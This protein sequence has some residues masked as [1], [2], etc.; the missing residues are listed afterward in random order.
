MTDKN[1]SAMDLHSETVEGLKQELAALRIE[2]NK[3]AREL[4][5]SNNNN[6]VLKLNMSSQADIFKTLEN[7]KSKQDVYVSLLLQSCPDSILV[8][9]EKLRILLCTNSIVNIID[10]PDP[11]L[12]QG[13]DLSDMVGRY[14]PPVFTPE[15][16]SSIENMAASGE[17]KARKQVEVVIAEGCY[18]VTILSFDKGAGIFAGVLVV[19]HNITELA[20]ARVSAENAN[21]AKSDFLA[22]MSHEIRTPMNAILGLL[23]SVGHDPLT[24]RQKSYIAH[25]K[26]SGNSLLN[27]INDILDFSKIEAGKFT[28]SPCNFDLHALLNNIGSLSQVTAREKKLKFTVTLSDDVPKTIFADDNRLRQVLNNIISNAIKYTQEGSVALDVF[29][30]GEMLNFQVTDTGIGIRKEDIA[31]LFSPFEQLDLRKN[32]NVIGTGLGLAITR[33]ICDSVGGSISVSSE[34]GR[35]S[36]FSIKIPLIVGVM[37]EA[38]SDDGAA[39]VVSFPDSRV[40]VVDDLDIN[41][42]VAEA[43]LG[44]FEIKPDL[45]LSGGLALDMIAQNRYDIIFMDQMMPEMDGIETTGNIRR[46]DDYYAAVPIVALTANAL[47]GVKD[48]LL[49]AGFSDYLS[50]PIDVTLLHKCLAKWLD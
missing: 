30:G 9:D 48:T 12:L 4:R 21:R 26:N 6:E 16:V 24:E 47:T 7:E 19:V 39:C 29:V 25:I 36:T 42:L 34:Y 35:G 8:F 44:E 38:A 49:A 22:N 50:K 2:R 15:V 37:E 43:L 18:D 32:K 11:V 5:A 1:E 17:A 20:T 3:L 46:Y 31:K 14:A 33:H 40:L 10:I 28:L 23:S 41:L 13:R 45:A 27:I